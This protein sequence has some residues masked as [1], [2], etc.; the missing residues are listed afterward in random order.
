MEPDPEFLN[1]EEA[2]QLW[3]RAAQLQAE[4]A[5]RAE[6]AESDRA[7]T[8]AAAGETA[9]VALAIERLDA[10]PA[11]TLSG[12]FHVHGGAS[13][14]STI[15]DFDRVR[16]FLAANVDV[17]VATDHDVVWD[18]ADARDALG[19]DARYIDTRVSGAG[20]TVTA[21]WSYSS[22]ISP[23]I[24]STMSSSVTMPLVPPN[25]STTTA[26]W[27]RRACISRRS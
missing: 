12:D 8:E 25:S 17:I 11:G 24:S 6:K 16:A 23:T 26:R 7:E 3:Q 13:F 14:D 9:D 20:N 15:P 19:A 18:Y 4:A 1:E 10:M 22:S 21:A 27:K 2:A 5:R